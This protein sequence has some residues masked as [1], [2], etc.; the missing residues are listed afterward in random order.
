MGAARHWLLIRLHPCGA[1]PAR[2][3]FKA[4]IPKPEMAAKHP[5]IHPAGRLS[6]P[7]APASRASAGGASSRLP[8]E[9]STT[10][11]HGQGGP[12][13]STLRVSSQIRTP[14][15]HASALEGQAPACPPKDPRRPNPGKEDLARIHP[16]GRPANPNA[17]AH[18]PALEGQA[19]ACPPKDPRRPN[20]GKEDLARIHP[21]G[22]L[23]NPNAPASRASAGGAS[24]RLPASTLR[25]SS[26]IRTPPHHASALEGQ[27][28]AC[29][30][31]DPLAP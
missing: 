19:P 6:N 8:A 22:R 15:H 11:K 2:V 14:P 20:P 30:P 23:A 21:A 26:Q 25:V 13:P 29:P 16:A 17:P 28:P 9:G 5:R 7:N 1:G 27:A 4:R 3:C 12:C 24:S 10:P 31:R 18:A